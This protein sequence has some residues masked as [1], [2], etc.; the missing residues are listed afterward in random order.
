MEQD[1]R[2][3]LAA[4]IRMEAH[5]LDSQADVLRSMAD[6]MRERAD[7]FEHGGAL[8]NLRIVED[9]EEE[10]ETLPRLRLATED[11]TSFVFYGPHFTHPVSFVTSAGA[12]LP[13]RVQ[14]FLEQF[15]ANYLVW[16]GFTKAYN[17]VAAGRPASVQVAVQLTAELNDRIRAGG[18]VESPVSHER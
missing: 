12:A 4:L 10:L 13:E 2:E 1:T 14:R 3:A 15:H 17:D 6:A 9:R 18:A 5:S 11:E 16:E 8:P 7:A